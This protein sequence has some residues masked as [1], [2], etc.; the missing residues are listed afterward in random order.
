MSNKKESIKKLYK[1]WSLIL[2]THLYRWAYSKKQ[3]KSYFKDQE[4][5][6]TGT[7]SKTL[8]G[9]EYLLSIKEEEEK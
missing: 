9:Q 4:I 3:A 8:N 1:F 7:Y 6:K 2:Q 5:K